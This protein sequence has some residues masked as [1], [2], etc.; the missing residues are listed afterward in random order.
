MNCDC[1]VS[2]DPYPSENPEEEEEEDEKENDEKTLKTADL[3]RILSSIERLT[4]ELCEI[5]GDFNRSANVKRSATAAVRPY[6]MIVQERKQQLK[7]MK[8]DAFFK[9]V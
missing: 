5:D 9:K 8:L 2:N 7:Q 4:D 1:I 3:I 6:A